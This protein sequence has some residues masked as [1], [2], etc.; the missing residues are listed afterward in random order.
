MQWTLSSLSRTTRLNM[1]HSQLPLKTSSKWT[2]FEHYYNTQTKYSGVET[3]GSGGSM[4]R[5]PELLR[6]RVVG[7]HKIFIQYEKIA[8]IM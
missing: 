6:P 3:G 4:N 1:K 5:G 8:L 2:S 7:P